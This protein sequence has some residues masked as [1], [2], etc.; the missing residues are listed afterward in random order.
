MSGTV[1]T[2]EARRAEL[3]ALLEAVEIAE[4]VLAQSGSALDVD[5]LPALASARG[6]PWEGSAAEVFR[7]SLTGIESEAGQAAE[8]G[9]LAAVQLAEARELILAELAGADA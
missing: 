9:R 1:M 5:A 7:M 3:S 2:G 6:V 8:S 4:G